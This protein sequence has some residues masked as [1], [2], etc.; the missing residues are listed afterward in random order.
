MR[1]QGNVR[2]TPRSL[3]FI[4][5]RGFEPR[6]VASDWASRRQNVRIRGRERL[7]ERHQA[8]AFE[9]QR[10]AEAGQKKVKPTCRVLFNLRA[11]VQGDPIT[12][13]KL[14]DQLCI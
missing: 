10:L 2:L 14:L 12:Q 11:I 6:A 4:R 7:C 1:S 9:R 8:E 13:T 5:F 3:S